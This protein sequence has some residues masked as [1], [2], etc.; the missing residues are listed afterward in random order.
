MAILALSGKKQSGK[1]TV[2]K[3]ANIILNSPQLNNQG[4]L[5]FLKKNIISNDNWQIKMFAEK[6]KQMV[7]LLIGCTME[8]LENETFKNSY[9]GESW[10]KWSITS[11]FDTT[12]YTS[13]NEALFSHGGYYEPELIKMTPRLLLQLLGTEC[14]REIIHPNIW[15]NSLMSEYKPRILP[16]IKQL[17]KEDSNLG[18]KEA[19]E[20]FFKGRRPKKLPEPEYPNWIITDMRFPSELE[21]VKSKS[22]ITIRVNRDIYHSKDVPGKDGRVVVMR[23]NEHPSETVLDNARFDY[24]INND[25]SLE[26]LINK[27]REILTK[28]KLI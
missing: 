18:L 5:D 10:N 2:G 13:Y 4:V 26:D 24:T 1:N 7:C 19:K 14:G 9:L 15:V 23:I 28:E 11:Q 21:A 27:V 25:G 3:I 16:V 12:Y 22:G 6:L 17:L 8:Q 20:E